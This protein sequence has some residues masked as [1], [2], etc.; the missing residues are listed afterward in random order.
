M[1]FSIANIS[2]Y[3]FLTLCIS[4]SSPATSSQLDD[5][6]GDG[7][8]DNWELSHNLNPND[9]SDALY[10]LDNDG[11]SNLTEYLENT[12]PN[13]VNSPAKPSR[14]G[15][16]IDKATET[17]YQAEAD[18]F[19]VMA[20]GGTG[21][22][23]WMELSTGETPNSLVFRIQVAGPDS[24][25]IPIAKGEYWKATRHN[26]PCPYVSVRFRQLY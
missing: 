16:W 12:D 11:Y 10:D 24:A 19:L 6:D 15:S 25:M 20:T 2:A 22:R 8:P 23:G 5:I 3:L 26:N 18:G 7:M 1:N 14:I 21:C 17:L 13:D 9:P 4:L